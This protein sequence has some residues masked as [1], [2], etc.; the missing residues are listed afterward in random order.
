MGLYISVSYTGQHAV[1]INFLV[2]SDW[3]TGSPCQGWP[4][5]SAGD[6]SVQ[7]AVKSHKHSSHLKVIWCYTHG[8]MELNNFILF[9]IFHQTIWFYDL[10][11]ETIT[12]S[13]CTAQEK[14]AVLIIQQ[15]LIVCVVLMFY[16][17]VAL[18]AYC[19]RRVIIHIK[20]MM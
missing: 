18:S 19:K 4:K 15:S 17:S 2:L 12:V 3:L 13:Q 1:S 10:L 5:K 6:I 8:I 20:T 11:T 16:I 9:Q 7:G 14:V